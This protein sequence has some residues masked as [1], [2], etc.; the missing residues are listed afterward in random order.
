MNQQFFAQLK[1]GT[2]GIGSPGLGFRS[3]IGKI[4]KLTEDLELPLLGN[5]VLLPVLNPTPTPRTLPLKY[6]ERFV[7]VVLRC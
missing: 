2:A 5:C 1:T 6:R 7:I 3:N 4:I